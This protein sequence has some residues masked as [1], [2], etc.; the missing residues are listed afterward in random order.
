M[1]LQSEAVQTALANAAPR[2]SEN[3]NSTFLLT[4]TLVNLQFKGVLSKESL[5]YRTMA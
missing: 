4:E 1:D 3:A 2:T 5:Y